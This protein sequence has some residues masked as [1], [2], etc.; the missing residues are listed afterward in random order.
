M[1]DP[2]FLCLIFGCRWQLIGRRVT[3]LPAMTAKHEGRS[4]TKIANMR[5]T[6][7][8]STLTLAFMLGLPAI[9][10]ADPPSPDRERAAIAVYTSVITVYKKETVRARRA[11]ETDCSGS[12]FVYS[13]EWW[14]IKNRFDR[15]GSKA[16]DQSLPMARRGEGEQHTKASRVKYSG[17]A[18]ATWDCT[19]RNKRNIC[20]AGSFSVL[21]K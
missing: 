17:S 6:A 10:S 7:A 5:L 21:L 14:V 15:A 12:G 19:R 3:T 1:D 16:S 11:V 18:T 8:L 4:A 13:C 2:E 9:S 20:T